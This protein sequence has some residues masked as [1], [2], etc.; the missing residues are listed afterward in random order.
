MTLVD[1]ER[2]P[3]V[4]EFEPP[5]VDQ[6]RQ[7]GDR[8][9]AQVRDIAVDDSRSYPTVD[10]AVDH[11]DC[12][13]VVPPRG[14][15]VLARQSLQVDLDTLT[16]IGFQEVRKSLRITDDSFSG[17]SARELHDVATDVTGHPDNR[18]AFVLQE[19][20]L[21]SDVGLV[22]TLALSKEVHVKQTCHLLLVDLGVAARARQHDVVDLIPL[23]NGQGGIKSAGRFR[24]LD[25]ANNMC[26]PLP[27]GDFLAA[28][29]ALEKILFLHRV[30]RP[31][32]RTHN[33]RRSSSVS[34]T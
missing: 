6:Q 22:F 33:V 24:R 5:Q 19:V 16:V 25:C 10:C 15:W 2:Y 27:R 31:P 12:L 14:K 18:G 9:D 21:R 20:G 32:A 17:C 7:P 13:V 3:P 29:A 34:A 8:E 1:V 26:P 28:E 30:Q 11:G 23:L 4:V